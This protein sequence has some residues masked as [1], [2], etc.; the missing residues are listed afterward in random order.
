[1][2]AKFQQLAQTDAVHRAQEHY[3]GKAQA[4]RRAPERDVFQTLSALD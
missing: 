2:A 1:M 3:Y 4:G